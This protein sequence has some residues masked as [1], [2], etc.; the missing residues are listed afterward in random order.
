[1][2]RQVGKPPISPFSSAVLRMA[3][4]SRLTC[5]RLASPRFLAWTRNGSRRGEAPGS[6]SSRA[7]EEPRRHRRYGSGTAFKKS[8]QFVGVAVKAAMTLSAGRNR[9]ADKIAC[10]SS[11]WY[12][13]LRRARV[14]RLMVGSGLSGAG[15]GI[16]RRQIQGPSQCADRLSPRQRESP[17]CVKWCRRYHQS[18]PDAANAGVSKL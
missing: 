7:G 14:P 1:M 10:S 16:R 12:R 4:V 9:V 3:R 18:S 6:S 11:V 15:A 8:N 2:N 13:H 5:A 17:N